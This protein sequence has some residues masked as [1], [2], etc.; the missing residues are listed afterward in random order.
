[1]TIRLLSSGSADQVSG[2]YL[3]NRYLMEYMRRAGV[4]VVYHAD[5]CAVEQFAAED[6]VIV[7]SLVI[8]DVVERLLATSAHLVLLLHVVPE[9]DRMGADG[10]SLL[11]TLY[12]R[13]RI[14]VTGDST[15]TTLRERLALS[16]IDAV[17]IEPGVPAQWRTKR[18]YAAT[19]RRLL[20]VANYIDGKGIG[21][22][23]D[24]LVR[25]KDLPWSW[26]VYGNHSLDPSYFAAA[27]RKAAA[28]GLLERVK[29]K[30]PIP[31]EA[32]NG[33]MVAADLL[34]HFSCRES[35][36]MVT[37][38]AIAAGLPVLSYRTGNFGEFVRSGLVRYCEH[39]GAAADALGALVA[40]APAYARLRRAKRR[41][42]RT[43]Q[44]VGGE[45]LTW[46]GR[47]R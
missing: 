36:S 39:D 42:Q 46:L 27:E 20:T 32:V 1:M 5:S 26:T 25:I 16:G 14:V 22:A 38:E 28:Y 11:E 8:A 4:E 19:A 37:A 29:L 12:R 41:E 18:R 3:Y 15:L 47:R 7:D 9:C 33:E 24:A 21:R 23:L 30:G 17:K 35:Y 43:W 40:N 44:D 13:S 6:I 10:E 31:H 45:F 34:V 2:G